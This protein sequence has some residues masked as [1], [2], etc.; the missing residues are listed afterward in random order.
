VLLSNRNLEPHYNVECVLRAFALVQARVQEA[1]LVVAGDGSQRRYL[2][3][4]A[5]SLKLRNVE[6]AGAVTPDQ[7]LAWYDQADI[8]VNASDIDNQPLS[9]IEA[10]ASGLPVVTTNAGG[11]PYMVVNDATGLMVECNDHEAL[12]GKVL[13]LLEISELADSIVDQARAE[14]EKYAWIKVRTQWLSMYSELAD[15]EACVPD[16]GASTPEKQISAFGE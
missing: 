5:Q 11:I 12:A 3:E 10:F 1:R 9:I 13:R 15:A 4:L 7:M 6:F 16:L 2:R 14:C 8:F